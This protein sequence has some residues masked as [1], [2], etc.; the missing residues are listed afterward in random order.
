MA[1]ALVDHDPVR[2]QDYTD[3]MVLSAAAARAVER[4]ISQ[5]DVPGAH[6]DIDAGL[7]IELQNLN[8][9]RGGEDGFGRSLLGRRSLRESETRKHCDDQCAYDDDALH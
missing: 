2:L 7:G 6:H 3:L 1:L 8:A 5:I 9:L 4:R